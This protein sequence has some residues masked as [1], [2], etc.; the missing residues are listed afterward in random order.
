MKSLTNFLL[1][2]GFTLTFQNLWAASVEKVKNDK[3]LVNLEGQ[4][5]QIDSE[6]YLLSDEG[7]KKGQIRILQVKGS[8]AI[9]TL[10]KGKAAPGMTLTPLED[11]R[12]KSSKKKKNQ[13]PSEDD[14]Y[15][16][17]DIVTFKK[18]TIPIGILVGYATDTMSMTGTKSGISASLAMTGTAY[19]VKGFYDYVLNPSLSLRFIGGIDGFNAS[20][21]T[22]ST[23]VCNGEST[24]SVKLSYLA[25]E[26]H[27]LWN[28]WK[29]GLK[30]MWVGGGYAFM[31]TSSASSNI[32]NFDTTGKTNS[33]YLFTLGMDWGLSKTNYIPIALQ[34][35][36]YPAGGGVSASQI[37]LI[38]GYGIQY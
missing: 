23:V 5:A 34:Y 15:T 9:A 32:A 8:K 29:S 21:S 4:P 19:S 10:I 6:F 22:T 38:S 31:L 20:S 16:D 26:G 37:A 36:S 7:T 18:K 11:H 1:I 33:L 27:A 13:D 25:F 2:I 3:I 35:G 17:S 28:F 12:Q 30:K 24:C 14:N